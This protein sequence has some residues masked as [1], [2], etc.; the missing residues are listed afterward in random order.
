MRLMSPILKGG[1]R[2]INEK[3]MKLPLL[4]TNLKE[5]SKYI[6]VF[7]KNVV[8]LQRICNL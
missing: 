7:K 1:K 5:I 4:G 3:L 6:C 2:K 8:P